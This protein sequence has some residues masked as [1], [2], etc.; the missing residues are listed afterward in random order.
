MAVFRIHS[1]SLPIIANP[2]CQ[3]EA[4]SI[5]S[6][7]EEEQEEEE[8]K[9]KQLC[10]GCPNGKR[11]NSSGANLETLPL[12]SKPFEKNGQIERCEYVLRYAK[13]I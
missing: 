9:K 11:W 4:L 12:K 3:V 5:V 10:L 1:H 2:R 7:T 8:Q 6:N 13:N